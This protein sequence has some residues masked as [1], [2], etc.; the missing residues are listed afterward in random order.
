VESMRPLPISKPGGR[1][2]RFNAAQPKTG[3][4]R[5]RGLISGVDYGDRGK[6]CYERAGYPG[7]EARP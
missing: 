7:K 4:S 2:G 5:S 6:E 1:R 3:G